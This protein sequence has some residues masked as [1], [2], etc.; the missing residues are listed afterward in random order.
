MF[1]RV[2]KQFG[3][4]IPSRY[5]RRVKGFSRPLVAAEDSGELTITFSIPLYGSGSGTWF[6]RV[7]GFSVAVGLQTVL[8]G[9][10]GL[11]LGSSV[12]NAGPDVVSY[13]SGDFRDSLGRAV[14]VFSNFPVVVV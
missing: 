11:T 9:V 13:V 8:G 5:W 12:P 10:L 1:F 14:P 7:G 2:P 4:A 3:N 6:V